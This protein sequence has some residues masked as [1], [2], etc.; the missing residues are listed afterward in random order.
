MPVI[1][2]RCSLAGARLYVAPRN[3][4]SPGRVSWCSQSPVITTANQIPGILGDR[5]DRIAILFKQ[6]LDY[7][8][9]IENI[10]KA[11]HG[12]KR[13]LGRRKHRNYPVMHRRKRTTSIIIMY[14]LFYVMF[15]MG[16]LAGKA[17][18]DMTQ[19]ESTNKHAV[20]NGEPCDS[21]EL[22]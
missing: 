12:K 6:L 13:G 19:Y 14:C 15:T 20:S 22:A 16:L 4:E 21:S 10:L 1:G 8:P 17:V 18:G 2:S 11:R 9:N 5:N 3:P 7:L